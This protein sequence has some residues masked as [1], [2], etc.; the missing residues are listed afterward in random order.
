MLMVTASQLD[1]AGLVDALFDKGGR[2]EVLL[3]AVRERVPVSEPEEPE[4]S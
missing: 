4:P 3:D 1:D 2:L